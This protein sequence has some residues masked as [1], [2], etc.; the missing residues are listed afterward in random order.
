VLA[1]VLWKTMRSPVTGFT[2]VSPG[3]ITVPP[4]SV[5]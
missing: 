4:P 2:M 5:R 3:L 1:E